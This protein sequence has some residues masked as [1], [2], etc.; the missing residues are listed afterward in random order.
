MT[1]SKGGE[2]SVITELAMIIATASYDYGHCNRN[3]IFI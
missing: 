2:N 3:K 1:N